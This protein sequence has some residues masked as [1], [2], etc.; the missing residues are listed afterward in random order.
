MSQNNQKLQHKIF[1]NLE[2]ALTLISEWKN[3]GEKI[4]FT[5][6]CFDLMHLGHIDYL[7]KAADL[8]T[9]LIIGLNSD[10]STQQLKG[11]TRPITDENSRA[12]VLASLFFVNAVILFSEKTPL[13]LI[14]NIEPDILVKGADYTIENIVGAK[15]VLGLG[16]EV[17]TIGFL[18]G[19]STSAIEAKIV[20][21][22]Q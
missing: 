22:H 20:K 13:D 16:G 2:S 11:P 19:Y 18:D 15:E 6:G 8:G 5:N 17:K 9:K 12:G 14:I 21:A 10:T 3:T 7:S 1:K 4:V